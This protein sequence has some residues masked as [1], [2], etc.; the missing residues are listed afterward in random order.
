[1]TISHRPAL[2]LGVCAGVL[3][4]ALA[5]CQSP[6]PGSTAAAGPS[7]AQSTPAGASRF[8]AAF[9]PKIEPLMKELT[10]PGVVV[11]V[12]TPN[13]SWAQAYGSRSL[14]DPA[15]RMTVDDHFRI[16]SNTKTM[17]GTCVLQL[18]SEG[19]IALADPVT[20]HLPQF[21]NPKL[22]GV[23]VQQLLEMSSG[24]ASYT[25]VKSWNEASDADLERVWKP[26]ELVDIGLSADVRFPPGQGFNYSNTNTVLLGLMVERYDGVPLEESFKRR[27]FD[28]LR[29]TQTLLPP[30]A[31]NA[32]PDPHPQ[33]YMYG[34]NVSTMDTTALSPAEQE[35][36]AQGTLKPG[37]YTGY[38][39]SWAW[40][41]GG[42]ISTATDL[43]PY[44]EALVGGGLLTPEMQ[45]QRLDS[46]KPVGNAGAGYG[47]ALAQFGP[48]LGH[49]GSLPGFTS[50]MGHDPKTKTTLIVLANLQ[51][52]PDGRMVA[53]EI[54]RPLIAELIKS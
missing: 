2:V 49:D 39:P 30:I 29:L 36:V 46:V 9:G 31:S 26:E 44:V 53:N 7:A 12:K 6:A 33:G 20:T 13:D 1:M 47:L 4:G 24:L 14:D 5:G 35:Q 23:T 21:D 40:A 38:N 43:V 54:A 25:E 22:N 10:V 16:G 8:D 11:A 34:T 37:N 51:S 50:F 41:A 28:R 48:M 42:G 27:I 15:D 32:I 3:V 17:T 52:A 19:R 18:V 45:Q